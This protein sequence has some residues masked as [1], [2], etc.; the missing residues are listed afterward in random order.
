MASDTLCRSSNATEKAARK[1]SPAPVASRTRDSGGRSTRGC[2]T[3][4][5]CSVTSRLP[6]PP[7]VTSMER[8]PR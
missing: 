2:R 5:P 8:A 6:R 1:A 7:R 4:W 3:T